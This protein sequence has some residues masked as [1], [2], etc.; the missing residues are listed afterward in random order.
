[1]NLCGLSWDEVCFWCLGDCQDTMLLYHSLSRAVSTA[2]E[3]PDIIEA[4][5]VVF[6]F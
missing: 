5:V 1:M 6:I 4:V 2:L 3:G